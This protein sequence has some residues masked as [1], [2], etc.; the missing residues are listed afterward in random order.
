VRK[1]CVRK[2]GGCEE[3]CNGTTAD[4]T[5][6]LRSLSPSYTSHNQPTIRKLI[7]K[8]MGIIGAVERS[9]YGAERKVATHT[10]KH[11]NPVVIAHSNI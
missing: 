11:H 2:G 7:G 4:F 9:W 3:G 8:A 1:A 10:R 6:T 5:S